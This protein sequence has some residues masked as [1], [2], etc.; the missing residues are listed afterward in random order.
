MK[1]IL[2]KKKTDNELL[3]FTSFITRKINNFASS[4]IE[5]HDIKS[6]QVLLFDKAEIIA[7]LTMWFLG[8]RWNLNTKKLCGQG[9][10]TPKILKIYK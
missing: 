4:Y 3:R 5:A 2:K 8:T 9:I 6:T 7:T 10:N 1:N